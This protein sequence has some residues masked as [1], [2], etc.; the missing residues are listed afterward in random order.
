MKL[1]GMTL[2]AAG[3][4]AK[5]RIN[6]AMLSGE[7]ADKA[8]GQAAGEAAL[9]IAQTLGE[10][11]GAAMKVGQMASMAAD[12]L[13]E[14]FSQALSGLQRNAPPMDYDVIEGQVRAEFGQPLETLFDR[15][16]REAFA[17]AS[18]GQVHRATT[19]DGREVVVKVQYPGVDGAVDSDMRHLKLALRAS[20]LVQLGREALDATFE[21]IQAR[22]HEELDY[23][24]EADNVRMFHEFH[25]RH[26]FVVVP[27]VV[28]ER[29]AKRVL[30]MTYEPGDSAAELDALGYTRAQRNLCG[31]NLWTLA[32]SQAFDFG[33]IHADP[34]P[35]N[36]AFR[37]DGTVVLYDFGC[38]KQLAE[39]V[40]PS[41]SALVRHGLAHEWG[42]LDRV[43]I[44][45]GVRKGETAAPPFEL[46]RLAVDCVAPEFIGSETFDF[47]ATRLEKR[48]VAEVAPAVLR[49]V[50]KFQP[51]K[52][53]V[54]FERTIAGHYAN[55]RRIGATVPV[56]R[57]LA[58]RIDGVAELL[59]IPPGEPAQ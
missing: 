33:R 52:E 9:R 14:E 31:T 13:P 28:G 51:D 38:V 24:N 39:H 27:Q 10:L 6:R 53:L 1:A 36:F 55:V 7:A 17:S 21:E 57:M 40:M 25:R 50:T 37:P 34:N 54:F 22:M 3:H 15:F 58:D 19:D 45:M 59:Q 11:K 56:Q 32:D 29:S 46:Y 4:Y 49:H 30:T 16:E 41:Y 47:H 35:A 12:L 8:R 42:E 48:V 44:D 5:G 2:S 23:C 18:I 43:L 20:G 26:P